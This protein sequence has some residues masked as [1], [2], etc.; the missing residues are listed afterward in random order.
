MHNEQRDQRSSTQKLRTN[1]ESIH[2]VALT[3]VRPESDPDPTRVR[4]RSDP[5]LTLL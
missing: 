5:G 1:P 2:I 4:P 3:P